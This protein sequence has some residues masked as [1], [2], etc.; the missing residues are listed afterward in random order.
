LQMRARQEDR[1]EEQKEFEARNPVTKDGDWHVSD[2]AFNREIVE[3][4]NDWGYAWTNDAWR[5]MEETLTLMKQVAADH[6]AELFV[7]L[8]PVRHQ[9]EARI[10]RDEPQRAFEQSMKRLGIA[11]LDLLP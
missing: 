9:V 3:A 11:H 1:K 4:F 7:V 2:G 6:D 5:K 10:L 8:L